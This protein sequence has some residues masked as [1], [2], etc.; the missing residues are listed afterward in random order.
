MSTLP[1]SS[2]YRPRIARVS[3]VLPE[4]TGPVTPINA[5]AGISKLTPCKPQV[6]APGFRKGTSPS[7][8]SPDPNGRAPLRPSSQASPAR[9]PATNDE[10][11]GPAPFRHG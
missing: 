6:V 1:D 2:G 5:P 9:R 7:G 11:G 3:A 10:S 8:G 4:P